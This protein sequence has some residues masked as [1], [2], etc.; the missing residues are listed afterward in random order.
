M[1]SVTANFMVFDRV[2]FWVLPLS[3]FCLPKSTRAYRFPQSV[4]IIDLCRGPISVDPHVSA[5]K[6]LNNHNMNNSNNVYTLDW[7][8]ILNIIVILIYIYIYVSIPPFARSQGTF[9]LGVFFCNPVGAGLSYAFVFMY[10]Y[11]Y[12]E[13]ER[14]TIHIYAHIHICV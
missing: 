13:R 1:G 12:I 8:Y 6:C 5:T 4:K 14:Y 11:I 10:I 3:Y 2:F 7:V 9:L